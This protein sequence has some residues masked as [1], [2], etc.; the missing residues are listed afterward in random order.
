MV[1]APVGRPSARHRL[2]LVVAAGVVVVTALSGCTGDDDPGPA[3][4]GEP[5]AESVTQT[6]ARDAAPQKVTVR[7]VF[8]TWPRRGAARH[9]AQLARAAGRA[10]TGWMDRA[11]VTVD[12][13]TAGPKSVAGAFATFTPGAGKDARRDRLT[14]DLERGAKLVDVVPTRRTVQLVAYA[15]R[16]RAVGATAVVQLVLLGLRADGA[17]IETAVTGE[18]YLSRPGAR[19]Q[20]FGYDL[21]RSVGAPGSFARAHRSDHRV[22]KGQGQPGGGGGQ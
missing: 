5:P 19:W 22:G 1:S 17:R 10:V 3:E 6:L 4:G 9:S 18:L 15:P 14:A 21:Q 2:T 7:H 11:Y 8:G 13:P 16:G 12:Y 20:V